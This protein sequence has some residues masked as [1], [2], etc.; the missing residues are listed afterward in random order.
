MTCARPV[1]SGFRA[2][3]LVVAIVPSGYG[4]DPVFAGA[5]AAEPPSR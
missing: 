3:R 5:A 2:R 1:R 4:C